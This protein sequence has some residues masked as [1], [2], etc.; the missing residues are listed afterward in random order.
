MFYQGSSGLSGRRRTLTVLFVLLAALVTFGLWV[1]AR[2]D[3]R[4]ARAEARNPPEGRF[5]EVEGVS[6]HAVVLG[7]A[8]PWVV[9][10]H[11]ASG[12]VRDWTF[13][14][15]DDL[16]R[17]YRVAI[18][19]R[20]GLGYSGRADPSL[21]GAF[22]TRAEA[23]ADQARL[24]SAAAQALGVTDPIVVGHSYGGAVALAWALDHPAAAVV[25]NAGVALPW[26]GGL[27]WTY[28]VVGHPLGGA[29]LPPL[30][31]ALLSEGY[32]RANLQGVFAPD[33][34]PDGY[35]ERGGVMLATRAETI[36]A[37]GRQVARLRPHVVEQ[38]A[39]YD[40]IAI[41]VEAVHGTADT[42]VPAD[43]H[44][45]PLSERHH[46]VRLTLVDGMGHMPHHTHPQVVRA[47]IDRAAGRAG[48]HDR[49]GTLD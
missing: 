22:D 30:A 42:I 14:F 9:L 18:F 29:L 17:D 28:D 6:L 3:L 45:I 19:D 47:A 43:I 32:L 20:P 25:L 46:G 21:G 38:S 34:V 39:R 26:P 49:A 48:L 23:P 33:P 10:I 15:A 13:S 36:R 1:D 40:E 16:A 35:L 24:L 7:E 41:P 12:N 44:A 11:G 4:A 2:A 8:G 5:V 27:D 31:S 37:N